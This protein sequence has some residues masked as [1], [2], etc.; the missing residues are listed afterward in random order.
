[1][2]EEHRFSARCKAEIPPERVEA[3]PTTRLCIQCSEEVGSD[4]QLS[5]TQENLAKPGSLKKN[6]G[7]VKVWANTTTN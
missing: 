2:S 7:G 6:H 4:F 1:M 5:F 3:I